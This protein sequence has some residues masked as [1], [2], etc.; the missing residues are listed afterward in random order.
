MALR[1][2]IAV[3]APGVIVTSTATGRKAQSIHRRAYGAGRVRVLLWR[4]ATRRRTS[5]PPRCSRPVTRWILTP[6]RRRFRRD[7]GLRV[8][9]VEGLG[10]VAA[11]RVGDF[12]HVVAGVDAGIEPSTRSSGGRSRADSRPRRPPAPGVD[13]GFLAD[14]PPGVAT[15]LLDA[16]LAGPVVFSEPDER[17]PRGLDR[18]ARP[19][20]SRTAR[21]SRSP[22]AGDDGRPRQRRRR[23]PDAIDTT[24]PSRPHP[25]PLRPRRA[26]S[27]PHRGDAPRRG[28][29]PRRA[30]RP[31]PRRLRRRDRPHRP[32][33]TP[34]RARAHH[35]ARHLRPRPRSRPRRRR[36]PDRRPQHRARP[37][38][39]NPARRRSSSPNPR[40]S[41][42]RKSSRNPSPSRTCRRSHD[43]R[44][45]FE[46]VPAR[47]EDDSFD[48]PRS[49]DEEPED[50][51][52]DLDAWSSLLAELKTESVA[53]DET[54]PVAAGHRRAAS[55]RAV[56]LRAGHPARAG[57]RARARARS[58]P[59]PEPVAVAP[60]PPEPEPT[61]VETTYELGISLDAFAASLER[62]GSRAG[63]RGARDGMS[64]SE[65]EA[66]LRRRRTISGRGAGSRDVAGGARGVAEAGA[67][68]VTRPRSG[69]RPTSRRSRRG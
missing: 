51:L 38:R 53:P 56:L 24:Q 30:R 11:R 59:E 17:A 63:A 3:A 69:W 65:L 25:E 20:R 27:S 5:T 58:A 12:T 29:P 62:G 68:S 7:D 15:R 46:P 57:A 33:P 55:P 4:R 35:R 1:I 16:A 6:A 54:L 9:E 14:A 8:S 39:G 21:H 13:L 31:R 41:S 28:R 2:T 66:S 34:A 26:W 43:R 42:R 40:R 32:P 48:E 64:L 50:E 61:P 37:P 67:S 22:P 23:G 36:A 44:S 47:A 52:P 19:T 60:E 45:P 49:I 18:L 10:L